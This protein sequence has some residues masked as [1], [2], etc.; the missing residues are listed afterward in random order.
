MSRLVQL[1]EKVVADFSCM[2]KQKRFQKKAI[3]ETRQRGGRAQLS[4]GEKSNMKTRIEIINKVMQDAL[5]PESGRCIMTNRN[6]RRCFANIVKKTTQDEVR[7]HQSPWRR[8]VRL[9]L[10]DMFFCNGS[11]WRLFDNTLK[12]N[13]QT[14]FT[15]KSRLSPK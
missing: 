11:F 2:R 15:N 14:L 12:I 7:Y 13:P 4:G 1:G 6:D 3:G 5:R 9:D 10:I 8:I